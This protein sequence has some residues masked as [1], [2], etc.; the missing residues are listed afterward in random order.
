MSEMTGEERWRRIYE[1]QAERLLGDLK[2]TDE[3]PIW[4]QGSLWP[5]H[6]IPWASAWIR[7]KYDSAHARMG[8]ADGQSTR[9]HR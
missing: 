3:G 2:E 7:R 6:E 8:L 1:T 4:E 9:P 5:A